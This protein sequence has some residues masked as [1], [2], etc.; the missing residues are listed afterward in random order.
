[1][2]T[3]VYTNN[4]TSTNYWVNTLSDT[5]NQGINLNLIAPFSTYNTID[6][7]NS[8]LTYLGAPSLTFTSIYKSIFSSYSSAVVSLKNCD[9]PFTYEFN[10]LYNV[11]VLWC[12]LI[13][14]A[15]NPVNISFPLY[16]NNVGVGF[17]FSTMFAYGFSDGS[18]NLMAYR[19]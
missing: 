3:S 10:S 12:P 8:M 17:P 6:Y 2:Q 4:W 5:Y 1:V 16:P 15:I 18:G 13:N 7:K 11:S 19:T 9:K 14:G